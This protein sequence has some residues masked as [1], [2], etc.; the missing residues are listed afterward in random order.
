MKPGKA[1]DRD[2]LRPEYD[3]SKAVRGATAERYREGVTIDTIP[4]AE[5]AHGVFRVGGTRVT[6]D[7]VI[8]AFERG[9]TAEEIACSTEEDAVLAAHPEWAPSGLR[10]RLL[11]RRKSQ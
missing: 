2:T 3:F 5:D 7:A 11:A 6:L 9:A 8:R 1:K 10:H 4:L